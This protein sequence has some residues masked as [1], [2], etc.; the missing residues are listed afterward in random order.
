[1]RRIALIGSLTTLK[2]KPKDVDLLVTVDDAVDL[3]PIAAIGRRLVGESYNRGDVFL[4]DPRANYIGRLCD[5]RDCFFRL[6][7]GRKRCAD[8]PYLCDDHRILKPSPDLIKMPSIELWPAVIRRISVP[9]DVERLLLQPL[10]SGE[11]AER[12]ESPRT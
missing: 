1:M 10:E 6:G 2:P 8:R 4:A 3:R 12:A 11:R 7:R 9:D 5:H